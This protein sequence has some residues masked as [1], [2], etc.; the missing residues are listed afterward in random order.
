MKVSLKWLKEYVDIVLLPQE[1]AHR[2][3]MS[4]SE[5]SSIQTVGGAWD[6]IFVAQLVGVSPHPNADR[7]HL[8]TVDLGTERITVVCGAPNLTI[9]DKVAFAKVGA[10]LI[11]GHSGQLVELKP[12]KIRGVPSE[13]MVCSEKELGISENYTGIMVLPP[14]APV[15]VPLAEYLGDTILDMD[16]TPNR[17]DCLSMIGVA[18][19]VAALTGQAIRP[20]EVSYPE[21]GNAIEES[22]SVDI[23]D[24]DLCSRYCASLITGV[25]I[26][27]S[28]PWMQE[29]I[30][31]SGMRPI[32]NIVDITNY[33]MMEY[34]QP[35]HAFDYEQL[36]ERKIIVR[37]ARR[38]ENLVT[39][40][41]ETRPITPDTLVIADGMGPIALAGVMGGAASEVTEGTTTILLESANFNRT[42]I[43]RTAA[44]LRIRTEA[45]LRFEKGL[46]PDLAEIALRRATRLMVELGGGSAARGIADVY[47]GKTESKPITLTS[48]RL[49]RVLGVK[50][51]SE[52]VSK[53]LGSLGCQCQVTDPS[54]WAM[55]VT[56]P[57][58]RTDI[59][60]PDDLAEEV[61][62][63]VGYDEIPNTT[64]S[65]RIPQQQ[66]MPMLSFKD[67]VRDTLVGCGLQEVLSYSLTSLAM[68]GRVECLTPTPLR[69]ANPMTVEQEYLRT[70][71][72]AG[73]LATLAANERHDENGLRLFE[74]GRAYLPRGNDLPEEREMLV[75]VLGGRREDTAWFARGNLMDFFDAK[76]V[77]EI[78]LSCLGVKPAF[79][80]AE[81][82]ILSPGRTASIQAGGTSLGVVGEV[83]PRILKAFD[84][85]CP[86][87]YLFE[88][89]LVDL[90]P[91]VAPT[92]EYQATSK[93]PPVVQ[94]IALVVDGAVPA[95]RIQEVIEASPLVNRATLF[96]VYA[97]A[98]VPAGKKSLA[99]TVVYQSP[100]RTLTDEEVAKAQRSIL[101]RLRH[102]LGAVLRS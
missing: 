70:T 94:D 91:L 12:A 64:L 79:V 68:L 15:G 98:P 82:A 9:G 41:G 89:S 30:I 57:Y 58:W 53:N 5:V 62:R 35:L 81:D 17:P 40:D 96:D 78:L 47:P 2:L 10:K 49:E 80:P 13:G 69:I 24:A 46:S 86:Q 71:L 27:P 22:I 38:G 99:Y 50:F 63:L 21:E 26:R 3:T 85:S 72:R 37:R 20:P 51:S 44:E 61:A 16:I 65:G 95:G 6:K 93:F 60:L 66:P 67:R 4:G 43:R 102:E 97:G 52:Q 84:I 25:T 36:A 42:S 73:I 48:N 28:P 1:L 55:S 8:A 23:L 39:L 54:V 76:G 101:A 33:V 19:E 83:H 29:R 14:E 7:L 77:V 56:V 11:D 45:S 92:R 34:G 18:R 32:N 88:M 74:V 31:A 100:T 87:V 75:G 90:L 59:R